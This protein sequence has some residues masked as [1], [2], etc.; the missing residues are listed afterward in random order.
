MYN[1]II[2]KALKTISEEKTP[3]IDNTKT[4]TKKS[5]KHNDDYYKEVE[6]KMKDYE[7]E[8]IEDDDATVKYNA[9][10]KQKEYHDQMEIR[11]GQEMIRYD[12]EPNEIY[13][14]RAAMSLKGD[15]KMGNKVNTGKWNPET[16]EGN[17]NTEAVWGA[18][19][20]KFGEKLINT[21]KASQKKRDDATSTIKQFGDDIEIEAEGK[22]NRGSKRKTAFEGVEI[23]K[24]IIKEGL[25]EKGLDRVRNLVREKGFR[26]TAIKLVDVNLNKIIGMGASDLPDTTTYASGLDE[27]STLL[28][29]GEYDS[30]WEEAKETAK[31]MLEDEGY[32][33]MFENKETIKESKKI[34]MKRLRFENEFGGVDKAMKLIPEGYK[35][36]EKEFVMTDGNETYHVRWEGS[37]TEGEAVI[38][39]AEN[40][41]LINEDMARMKSLW[42]FDSKNTLGTLKPKDR[43]NENKEFNKIMGKSK[44]LL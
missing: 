8:T 23:N 14:E 12:Q 16:G 11:N 9:T 32:P 35:K 5:G 24:K 39:R 25:S 33:G 29:S 43:M 36:N 20:D 41:N 2:K 31:M 34:G 19:D 30:A 44:E 17:G 1:N 27:I 13:K 28:E 6:S 10:D 42:S 26:G 37:L 38:L 18:S 3:G 7:K 21:A 15:S 22:K 4:V 40:Q